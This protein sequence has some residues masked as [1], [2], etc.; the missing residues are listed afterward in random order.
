M[1]SST[2]FRSLIF[3][4]ALS[5]PTLAA[6]D[7]KPTNALC[8]L[9]YPSTGSFYDLRPLQAFA[10]WQP[11][12]SSSSPSRNESWHARGYDYP[13]NFTV[14]ICGPVVENLTDVDGVSKTRAANISAF[15]IDP[16]T[17]SPVSI[18]QEN[19]ALVF[20]GK[21]LLLTYTNGSPC[22]ELDEDGQP[23][24]SGKAILDDDDD[25]D[26]DEDEK[27]KNPKK[28]STTPSTRHKSTLLSFTCD[29]SPNSLSHPVVSFLGS[30]DHC[31][32]IFEVKS[33]WACAGATPSTD[34]GSLGPGGVFGVILGIACLV[35]L[36][37]GCVYNRTVMHQR[38]WR[39]LPNYA[40][41]S[42]IGG[43]VG[44]SGC[45]SI[46]CRG[47][48]RER[49]WGADGIRSRSRSWDVDVRGRRSGSGSGSE[50][51]DR[52]LP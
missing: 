48:D 11:S 7:S 22:P 46:F 24:L 20:R 43:F 28:P 3:L 10:P 33:R 38:G 15:Y 29:T 36:I 13:A 4:L 34:P 1:T 35:Y 39:Q 9:H 5:H 49:R 19:D 27:P 47:R 44:V 6:T 41:W 8:T 21:K 31:T 17:N 50:D 2:A 18:G 25:D 30:P 51:E 45:F 42:G 14:N 32:Y 23:I 37:G 26:E 52:K 12:K 40:V 16:Q